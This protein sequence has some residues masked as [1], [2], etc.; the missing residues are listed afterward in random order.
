MSEKERIGRRSV[1][2]AS[3]D[4]LIIAEFSEFLELE[5]REVVW[6]RRLC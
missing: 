1:F 4:D 6:R 2:F 3:F 5:K